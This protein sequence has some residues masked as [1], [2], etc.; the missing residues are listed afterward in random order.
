MG[1]EDLYALSNCFFFLFFFPFFVFKVGLSEVCLIPTAPAP[2]LRS[3]N[4]TNNVGEYIK[5]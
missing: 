1:N 4:P 3:L 2:G 5:A